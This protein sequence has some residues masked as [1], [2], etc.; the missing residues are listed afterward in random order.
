MGS[1]VKP[2][3]AGVDI[4]E[5]NRIFFESLLFSKF[6]RLNFASLEDEQIA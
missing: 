1:K 5:K 6:E 3:A 4:P 2:A